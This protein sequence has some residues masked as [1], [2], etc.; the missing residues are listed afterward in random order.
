MDKYTLAL[1]VQQAKDLAADI[2]QLFHQL[3]G[4]AVEVVALVVPEQYSHHL[5]QTPVVPVALDYILALVEPL[6]RMQVVAEVAH[7]AQAQR[8]LAA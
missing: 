1:L 5:V 4:Q 2:I 7:T 6:L 3:F 8:L